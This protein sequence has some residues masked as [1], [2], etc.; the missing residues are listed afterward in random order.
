MSNADS[1]KRAAHNVLTRSLGLREKQS[2]LIFADGNSIVV[3]EFV[4]QAAADLEIATSIVFVPRALQGDGAAADGLPLPVEAAIRETDAVL[5]CLSDRPEHLPYRLRVLRTGWSRRT[6]LAHAPGLT[7]DI[8]RKADTDYGLIGE[9]CRQLALALILGRRM[10]IITTDSQGR[11]CR[12]VIPVGAWDHPPVMSDGIIPDGAWANVPPGETFI[13]PQGGDGKIAINGALPGRILAPGDEL[14][15]TFRGGYLAGVEP[16]S[17]PAGRHLHETQIVY[18]RE[19][20]DAGWTNLAEV[21][22]GL[23]PAVR[24][25]TGIQLADTKKTDT[26]HVALGHSASLGG[27]V[28]SAIHCD[29]VVERPTVRVDGRPLLEA[30]QWRMAEADWRLDQRRVA[31]PQPWWVG[32]TGVGRSAMRAERDHDRLICRWNAGRG[33]WDS[34]PVGVEPTS[35]LAARLYDLLPEGGGMVAKDCLLADAEK[36]GLERVTLPAL[37]WIMHQYGVVRA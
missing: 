1:L 13:V 30:G 16:K 6:K 3:A 28:D 24:E 2:L 23:N 33:R 19:C 10:E 35:R 31:V 9:R 20:G 26:L 7:L 32:V 37:I 12:L 18:A 8:L 14:I 17:G 4:A 34:T 27:S 29:L 5:S 36:A 15:L 21:G 11:E 25:L 22:F